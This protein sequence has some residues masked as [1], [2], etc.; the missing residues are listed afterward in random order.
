MQ[1]AAARVARLDGEI[2]SNLATLLVFYL[3][4][5]RDA[6]LHQSNLLQARNA[7][8]HIVAGL[9]AMDSWIIMIPF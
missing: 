8:L 1:R 6:D 5:A 7:H 3:Q 2:W 9:P 4:R